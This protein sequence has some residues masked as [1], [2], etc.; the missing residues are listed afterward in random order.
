MTGCTTIV[1]DGVV[2]GHHVEHDRAGL[3]AEQLAERALVVDAG[4]HLLGDRLPEERRRTAAE[5]LFPE[6][7]HDRQNRLLA[8]ER[9]PF[10]SSLA[11]AREQFVPRVKSQVFDQLRAGSR[12]H[13]RP[14]VVG[15]VLHALTGGRENQL[16]NNR[17]IHL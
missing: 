11:V 13:G 3:R 17:Q 15:E 4:P 14:A 8:A 10:G 5:Q 1:D 9:P 7:A 12:V 16:V 6:L 2:Q